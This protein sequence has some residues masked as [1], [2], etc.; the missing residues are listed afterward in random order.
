MEDPILAAHVEHLEN[1]GLSSFKTLTLPMANQRFAQVGG[2]LI[3]T[4]NDW[5][6]FHVLDRRLV[7][8]G[9]GQQ[10]RGSTSFGAVVEY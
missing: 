1:K 3:R 8:K 2:R 5:G 9:Y 10:L 6:D 7:E 4:E